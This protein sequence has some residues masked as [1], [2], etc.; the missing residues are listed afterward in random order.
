MEEREEYSWG[1]LLVRGSR[2]I[3][4]NRLQTCLRTIN[5]VDY[6]FTLSQSKLFAQ[7]QLPYLTD[8]HID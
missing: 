4:Q 5:N 3:G 2:W 6:I 8:G 7:T 1:R